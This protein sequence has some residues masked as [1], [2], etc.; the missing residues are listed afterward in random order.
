MSNERG[1]IK[2]KVAIGILLIA[3]VAILYWNI[4]QPPSPHQVAERAA[5]AILQSNGE[6]LIK[7][8]DPMEIEALQLTPEKLTKVTQKLNE[9][10]RFDPQTLPEPKIDYNR[11]SK[12]LSY[13][14]EIPLQDNKTRVLGFNVLKT[15]HGPRLYSLSATLL[16]Y[17]VTEKLYKNPNIGSGAH[18]IRVYLQE[19]PRIKDAF[20][21]SGINGFFSQERGSQKQI[22]WDQYTAMLE[23]KLERAEQKIISTHRD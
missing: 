6:E 21:S 7:L 18:T 10:I 3:L 8:L 5:N 15:D 16:T 9:G 19:V 2:Y 14:Q 20:E 4:T 13:F 17:V 12:T 23:S 11:S 22:T 1:D